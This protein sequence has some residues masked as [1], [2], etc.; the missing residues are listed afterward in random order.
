MG[1]EEEP[2]AQAAGALRAR[3]ANGRVERVAFARGA[4][5]LEALRAAGIVVLAPCGGGG[6]CGRCEVT[7]AD[8]GATGGARRVLACQTPAADGMEVL[9]DDLA[10]MSIEE[11]FGNAAHRV[12]TAPGADT[13]PAANASPA[14][15]AGAGAG[16]P[17]DATARTATQEEADAAN[18]AAAGTEVSREPAASAGRN[19]ASGA[20]SPGGTSG[21]TAQE[22]ADYGGTRGGAAADDG[23]YGLAVDIGTTTLAFYLVDLA[24]LSVLET[25]GALNP[26]APFGA[27]VIARIDAASDLTARATLRD[28]VRSA[29]THAATELC[30]RRGI[31]PAH[32]E[33]V[34]CAGNT[35]MESLVA[36]IDP[37]PLGVAPFTPSSLF[38]AETDLSPLA[39]RTPD[40]P[41]AGTA[42][43]KASSAALASDG[44]G[45]AADPLAAAGS[46]TSGGVAPTTACAA[47]GDTHASSR[48]GRWGDPTSPDRAASVGDASAVTGAA[49]AAPA[50]GARTDAPAAAR[51]VAANADSTETA[52]HGACAG[53]PAPAARSI[54]ALGHAYLAPAVAAYVGGDIT[55]GLHASGMRA[56]RGLQLF[57]DIG[58]NGEMALGNAERVVCCATAAGPAFEGA[59]ISFGMPALPGAIE[60]VILENGQLRAHVIG[61]GAPRG[62][63]GSGLLD[64]VACLLDAGLIDETGYLLDADEAADEA[65]AA[66]A[67][68]IGEE[69]GQT[70][71]YLDPARRVW[72]SQADVRQT[73][74][75]KAAIRDRK[76][77]V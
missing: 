62:L 17:E 51:A 21:A 43:V 58:T 41:A 35:V 3:H 20:E 10:A 22:A 68:L 44:R 37:A 23:R 73:Q 2:A 34:S 52:P 66:L 59:G 9:L 18:G 4:T 75:A 42:P 63:C 74:L 27:D 77:V 14:P 48:D 19:A 1:I 47:S 7:L 32:L 46:P 25:T 67:A 50:C 29:I 76:S 36:G 6:T 55:A 16:S 49:A 71:C 54:P 31:E 61:E 15:M 60:A 70:V 40:T 65:P 33:R 24:D 26:Q 5:L 64:A 56:R 11:G 69:D 57:V 39:S 8:D 13:T 12:G 45:S 38:G 53:D 30:A 72:L 28:G